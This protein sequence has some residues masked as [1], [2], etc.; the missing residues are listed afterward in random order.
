MT[1]PKILTLV[2]DTQSVN[3]PDS[4]T[5]TVEGMIIDFKDT[6][7]L[8]TLYPIVSN[9]SAKLTVSKLKHSANVFCSR[10][11]NLDPSTNVTFFTPAFENA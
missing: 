10:I 6:H 9:P 8:K 2:N 1:F 7:C 4:I 3:A 11:V 5:I